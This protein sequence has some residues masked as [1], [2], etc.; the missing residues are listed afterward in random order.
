M[1]TVTTTTTTR[2]D[3]GPSGRFPSGN[4]P[5]GAD[6]NLPNNTPVQIASNQAR[7]TDGNRNPITP[8]DVALRAAS[9]RHQNASKGITNLIRI[10][11]QARANR[12]KAQ[13]DIA[14]Y[15]QAYND[16]VAGQ[17]NAQNDII[18]AETRVSQITTAITSLTANGDDL[19]N[20]INQAVAQNDALNRE[21]TG[22]LDGITSNEGKKA[23]LLDQ[24]KG[25]DSQ[26]AQRVKE[27]SDKGAE[28]QQLNDAVN[29]KARELAARQKEFDDFNANRTTLAADVNDKAGVVD[30]L[31]NRL[32]QAEKALADAKI[33]LADL[34]N[35]RL[36]LPA[37]IQALK[38]ELDDLQRRAQACAD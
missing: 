24:L 15:T 35:Q 8:D 29:A 7:P 23:V 32:Q 16:A 17:R 13:N 4:F 38:A 10:I 25:L 2:P 9:D 14:P 18:A 5:T 21:K 36:Q 22:I 34:D 27:L 28:C 12:D 20:R 31:R 19:R 26:V 37:K 30:D 1:S 3:Y 11:D 33:R 6:P